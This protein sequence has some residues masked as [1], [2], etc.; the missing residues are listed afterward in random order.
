MPI[1][2]L[3]VRSGEEEKIKAFD[4]GANDYVT[5]PFGT[6]ELLARLRAALRDAIDT[7]G[8]AGRVYYDTTSPMAQL[9]FGLKR[10]RKLKGKALMAAGY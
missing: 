6:G 7:A 3:S 4:L 5:K 2:V 1:I 8:K 9:G 10:H